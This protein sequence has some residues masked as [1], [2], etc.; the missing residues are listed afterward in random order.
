R[1]CDTVQRCLNQFVVVL[2]LVL[3]CPIYDDENEHDDEDKR[4][5]R[6]ATTTPSPKVTG[7]RPS[8]NGWVEAH[9]T[10]A[11]IARR[12]RGRSRAVRWSSRNRARET[13]ARRCPSRRAAP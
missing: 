10:G 9:R 4:F 5:A 13:T 2:L 1:L 3:D 12:R 11:P 6:P 7:Q 8:R